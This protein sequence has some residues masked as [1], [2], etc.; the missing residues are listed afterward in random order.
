MPPESTKFCLEE[1]LSSGCWSVL[2]KRLSFPSYIRGWRV[3]CCTAVGTLPLPQLFKH[4]VCALSQILP[5][6]LQRSP[7]LLLLLKRLCPV[8]SLAFWT[9]MCVVQF[10]CSCSPG[11]FAHSLVLSLNAGMDQQCSRWLLFL[12]GEPHQS[13]LQACGFQHRS[14]WYG[15]ENMAEQK[16]WHW[17]NRCIHFML[18]AL[19]GL[20]CSDF[21]N[22][23]DQSS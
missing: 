23:S 14:G 18:L 12:S 3:L 20:F 21:G 1:Q 9:H 13:E 11:C 5:V 10:L 8:G 7:Y 15:T 6:L 4:S 19:F 2:H 16:L 22:H 17:I